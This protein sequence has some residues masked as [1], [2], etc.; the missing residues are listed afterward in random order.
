MKDDVFV[1]VIAIRY[2]HEIKAPVKIGVSAKPKSR[3]A[4]LQTASPF[5]L[6]LVRQFCFPNREIA[7]GVEDC[8]HQTQKRHAMRGEWFDMAPHDAVIVLNL[9]VRWHLEMYCPSFSEDD[10]A[11][12]LQLIGA[13]L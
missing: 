8:F 12:A 9:H 7:L 1:Y 5:E 11:L 3:V 4:E 10:R 2:G 6:V 13:D